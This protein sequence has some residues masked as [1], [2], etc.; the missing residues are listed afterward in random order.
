LAGR[1]AIPAD[2]LPFFDVCFIMAFVFCESCKREPAFTS[3]H[4]MCSDEYWLDEAHAMK[5]AGWVVKDCT[6]AFCPECAAKRL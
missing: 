2:L 1:D 4:R 6:T 3:T 5:D